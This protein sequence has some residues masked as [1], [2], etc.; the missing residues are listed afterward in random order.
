[1]GIKRLEQQA[2][3]RVG[4]HL[5]QNL[6][7][8]AFRSDNESGALSSKRVAFPA[9]RCLHPHT[10]RSHDAFQASSPLTARSGERIKV[11][12]ASDCILTAKGLC[13]NKCRTGGVFT[14]KRP[15]P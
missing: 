15:S 3:V 6:L 12:G 1:S 13:K 7:D 11:R 8:S 5:P 4:V 14:T 9:F 10:I 2:I